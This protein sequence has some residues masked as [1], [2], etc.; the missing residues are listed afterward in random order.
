MRAIIIGAGHLGFALANH[1]SFEKRGFHIYE[2]AK[3]NY[4]Y[5]HCSVP[6]CLNMDYVQNFMKSFDGHCS[7]SKGMSYM[8]NN[9][10]FKFLE[11]KG[12]KFFF[13]CCNS[14]AH[15]FKQNLFSCKFLKLL[16]FSSLL[17]TIKHFGVATY[18]MKVLFPFRK[19]I[20]ISQ[21]K[22]DSP[23]YA[24]MHFLAPHFPYF[25]DENGRKNKKEDYSNPNKYFS[26][27]KYVNKELLKLIDEIK[28]NMKP[29]S[30]I[31]IHGDHSHLRD[32]DRHKILLTVYFPE[33]FDSS[34]IKQNLTLVNLFRCLLNEVFKTDYE[35]L[36]DKFYHVTWGTGVVTEI[37]SQADNK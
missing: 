30:I 32:L 19:Y 23:K 11:S 24:Y 35:I 34:C 9:N 17:F 5:T 25:F 26:Y 20:K 27:M 22:I 31:I 28:Q 12:Y 21:L 18:K 13:S 15:L 1:A 16:I 4:D 14:F 36:E 2:E 33:G 6:S 37:S 10:L 3:S 29:N 8:K 7:I